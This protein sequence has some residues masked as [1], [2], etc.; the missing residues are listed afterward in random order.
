MRTGPPGERRL[1][2]VVIGAM[3]AGL[4]AEMGGKRTLADVKGGMIIDQPA[5]WLLFEREPLK[6]PHRRSS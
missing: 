4:M 1:T 3:G 2:D 6:I 5:A